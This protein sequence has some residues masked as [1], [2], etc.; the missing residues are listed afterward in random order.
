MHGHIECIL[1]EECLK[2]RDTAIFR[3]DKYIKVHIVVGVTVRARI[4]VGV[5]AHTSRTG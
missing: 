2:E 1:P 5:I 4:R 3:F